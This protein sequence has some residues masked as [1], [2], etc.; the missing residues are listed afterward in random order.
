MCGEAPSLLRTG[1]SLRLPTTPIASL[2]GPL[3]SDLSLPRLLTKART[4]G[5]SHPWWSVLGMGEITIAGL[6]GVQTLEELLTG[7]AHH[8]DG[9]NLLIIA[10]F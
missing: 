5:G 6:L 4:S 1:P 7:A 8:P 3:V 2:R 10:P 9:N